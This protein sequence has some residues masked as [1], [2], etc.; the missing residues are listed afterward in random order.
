MKARLAI[1]FLGLLGWFHRCLAGEIKFEVFPN[2][3]NQ[4]CRLKVAE[5]P[6]RA[7]EIQVFDVLGKLVQTLKTQMDLNGSVLLPT[8]TLSNGWYFV[9]VKQNAKIL[10]KR[11]KVQHF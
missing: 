11:V 6:E 2:P 7:V 3:C 9:K 10:T 5:W 8:E 1:T 4:N